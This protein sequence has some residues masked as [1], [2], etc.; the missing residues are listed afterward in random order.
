M[1]MKPWKINVA[2]LLSALLLS[3]TACGD[4]SQQSSSAQNDEAVAQRVA[5]K[6]ESALGEAP[7]DVLPSPLPGFQMA[8][9]SGGN[10]F[11]SDDGRYLVYG[12][13]F[14]LEN[15]MVEVTN[16]ALNVVRAKKLPELKKHAIQYPA[17]GDE[18]YKVYV[19]T[20]ITCG[21]CRKMHRQM[22]AYQRA[23]ISV[24]Y[25]AFPRSPDSAVALKKIWCDANPAQAMSDA[26][27]S[28]KITQAQCDEKGAVAMMH[29]AGIEFGVR[30]TPALLLEDGT[31]LSG[32]RSPD[33]L[34]KVLNDLHAE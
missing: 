14:D 34:L 9:T 2:A 26:M 18:Q 32:Y 30:G 29:D 23:G 7:S 17:I 21:Y 20:D 8:V 1:V 3:L 13:V 22:D 33:D 6:V 27:L 12:R 16:N 31:L 28:D 24:N 19:F 15:G 10:F 4:E 5:S 25:L 11:V